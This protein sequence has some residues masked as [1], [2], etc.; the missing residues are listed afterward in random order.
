MSKEIISFIFKRQ[1]DIDILYTYKSFNRICKFKLHLT[2]LDMWHIKQRVCNTE[3]NLRVFHKKFYRLVKL[4]PLNYLQLY[5]VN[6]PPASPSSESLARLMTSS[7][8]SKVRMD[9][10]E[11]N[12][13]SR[14]TV[15]WSS[16]LTRIQGLTK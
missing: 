10:T 9:M 5:L 16:Q 6:I 12:T 14:T 4:L 8:E 2:V 1:Y 7:S 15:M 13:S 3:G 11:P